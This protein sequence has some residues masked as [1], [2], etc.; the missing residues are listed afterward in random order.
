MRLTALAQVLAV[1][2]AAAPA[3]A[4]PAWPPPSPGELLAL[5]RALRAEGDV[6]GARARLETALRIAPE[7]DDARHELADVLLSE[8][9]DLDRAAELL[10]GV[11]LPRARTHLLAA[12]LAELRSDDAG[13]V[14]AYAR[15]LELGDDPD[16]RIRRALALGRLGR[17]AEAIEELK[18]VRAARPDD[19][20]ARG[21]LARL[22]EGAGR[23]REAE[24]EYR[25]IAESHPERAQGWEDLA[26]FCERAGRYAEAR[27]A[28]R[29][30]RQARGGERARELRPLPPSR[31]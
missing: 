21:G 1:A 6:A 8:G 18:R 2:L 28:H 13:A 7:F 22:Y 16:A 23:N 14:A 19:P 15:A 29:R 30:A 31:R 20:L 24:R 3:P 25:A 26:R 10:A 17:T 27:A 4:V 5:S 12:R 11:R 9:I